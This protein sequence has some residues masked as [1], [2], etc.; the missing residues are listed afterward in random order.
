MRGEGGY[1][2]EGGVMDAAAS[3]WPACLMRMLLRDD[4]WAGLRLAS[5]SSGDSRNPT[6]I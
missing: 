5:K 3:L 1:C 2:S 4:Y 6:N